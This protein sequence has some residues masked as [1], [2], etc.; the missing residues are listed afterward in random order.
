M[1]KRK[2]LVLLLLM[3]TISTTGF[4][5]FAKRN[6]KLNRASKKTTNT[7]QTKQSTTNPNPY[8]ITT[9][10]SEAQS[11]KPVKYSNHHNAEVTDL[12]LNEFQNSVLASDIKQTENKNVVSQQA[13]SVVKPETHQVKPVVKQIQKKPVQYTK[14]KINLFD[15]IQSNVGIEIGYN[16]SFFYNNKQTNLSISNINLG[17]MMNYSL[18]PHF[19]FQP[20]IRYITKGNKLLGNL[21][22]E[23]KEKLS[24][25]YAEIP[26]NIICKFGTPGNARIMIGA[27][28]YVSYL[29]GYDEIN[30]ALPYYGRDDINTYAALYKVNSLKRWDYGVSGMIGVQSPDGIN[31]KV[32]VETGLYNLMQNNDGT[33]SN[34]NLNVMITFG[35]F[36]GGN[37]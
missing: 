9:Y 5:Y 11:N 34:R 22:V 23:T 6:L 8:S 18:N 31:L 1:K 12:E 26:A 37:L 20:G 32:S 7:H 10:E 14:K 3:I 15:E 4:N 27:G 29:I 16:E 13:D 24:L 19:A 30:K 35:Y 36:F 21:D 17:L 25:H 28:P 2:F 33:W